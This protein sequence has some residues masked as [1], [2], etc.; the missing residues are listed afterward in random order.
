MAHPSGQHPGR[1]LADAREGVA[2]QEVYDAGAAEGGLQLDYAWG[3]GGYVADE[4]RVG[5]LGVG[6][7]GGQ[8]LIC[9]GGIDY[10]DQAAFA[11]HVHGVDA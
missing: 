11:G 10:Y 2:Y 3:V 9:L 7:E 8:G 1:G 5:A 4:G 6:A